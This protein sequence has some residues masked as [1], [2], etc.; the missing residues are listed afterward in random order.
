METPSSPLT[1]VSVSEFTVDQLNSFANCSGLRLVFGLNALL[2]APDGSWNSSNAGLLLRYCEARGYH[3]SWELGNGTT[4]SSG[5]VCIKVFLL[6]FVFSAVVQ[7]RC[8][9]F[10]LIESVNQSCC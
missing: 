8:I 10:H 3:M 4:G 2:R 9:H 1:L 5:P 6:Q 7:V